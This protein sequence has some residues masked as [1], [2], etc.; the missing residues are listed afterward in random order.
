MLILLCCNP[1]LAA[2]KCLLSTTPSL[3]PRNECSRNQTED[4]SHVLNFMT[5]GNGVSWRR[6]LDCGLADSGGKCSGRGGQGNWCESQHGSQKSVPGACGE[7]TGLQRQEPC[8]ATDQQLHRMWWCHFTLF[9]PP[10]LPDQ[11]LPTLQGLSPTSARELSR[12]SLLVNT[13][14][15]VIRRTADV[16]WVLRMSQYL[17]WA[18]HRHYFF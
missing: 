14:V 2:L 10:P 9:L 4:T 16:R 5:L 6:G 1:V 7:C 18:F 3:P 17:C 11:L 13:T 8:T 12:A 15:I